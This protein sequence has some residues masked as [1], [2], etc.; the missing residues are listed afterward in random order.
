MANNLWV[1]ASDTAW[2]TTGNWSL[3][4]VPVSTNNV[5]MSADYSVSSVLSGFAQS[6]VTLA[7]LNI[8][9]SYTGL[10]GTVQSGGTATGYLNIGA[11]TFNIG[12]PVP[13]GA[14][15]QG[16]SRININAANS[17]AI[18][19]V[20]GSGQSADPGYTPVLLLGTSLV[21]NC[22]GGSTGVALNPGETA[23]VTTLDMVQGSSAPSVL[24]GAGCTLT[25]G[26]VLAGVLTNVSAAASTVI[27]RGAGSLVHLGTGGYTALTIADGRTVL[28]TGTG[29]ITSLIAAGPGLLDFSQGTGAV[30]ITNYTVYPGFSI[31]DPLGRVTFTNQPTKTY[32]QQ[33]AYS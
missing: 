27:V 13:Q 5:Y 10:I 26:N 29:T 24:L 7:S 18:F 28:Y 22:L 15:S 4:A 32:V 31:R 1:S 11:T 20:L 3:A 23:S 33:T 2:S 8:D 14:A 9:L 16:S 19:N 6:A 21:L 25:T 30:T 17:G 12:L